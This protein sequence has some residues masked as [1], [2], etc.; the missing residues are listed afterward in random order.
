MAGMNPLGTDAVG[1]KVDVQISRLMQEWNTSDNKAEAFK[2]VESAFK[3][4]AAASADVIP[5]G[6]ESEEEETPSER[7]KPGIPAEPGY[8]AVQRETQYVCFNCRKPD[9]GHTTSQ[10]RRWNSR[11]FQPRDGERAKKFKESLEEKE[12]S[13]RRMEEDRKAEDAE[14]RALRDDEI[15]A[16]RNAR[17]ERYRRE[18]RERAERRRREDRQWEDVWAEKLRAHRNIRF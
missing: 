4:M 18:D 3:R 13:V 1:I 6:A 7:A 11:R 14:I 12:R 8:P 15:R 5:A 17:E 2:K 9:P 10:C 16:E